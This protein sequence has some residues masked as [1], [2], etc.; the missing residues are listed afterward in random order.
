MISKLAKSRFARFTTSALADV[1]GHVFD[2]HRKQLHLRNANGDEILDDFE[3]LNKIGVQVPI[4]FLNN[5]VDEF[6]FRNDIMRIEL[7]ILFAKVNLTK[8]ISHALSSQ[9]FLKF[10][11]GAFI[12]V[13]NSKTLYKEGVKMV[14][15]YSALGHFT[16]T[17]AMQNILL[18]TSRYKC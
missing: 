5:A 17:H 8:S 16:P 10:I 13:M 18:L 14:I 1:P 3:S 9:L 6:I 2:L 4:E 15:D 7:T 11:S 12:K